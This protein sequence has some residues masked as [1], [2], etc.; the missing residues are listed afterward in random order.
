MNYCSEIKVNFPKTAQELLN[1][2]HILCQQL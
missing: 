2:L 1:T